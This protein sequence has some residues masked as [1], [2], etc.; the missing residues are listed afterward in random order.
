MCIYVCM[1][2]YIYTYMCTV[3]RY[4]YVTKHCWDLNQASA[5]CNTHSRS[6]IP[7]NNDALDPD[8]VCTISVCSLEEHY[9]RCGKSIGVRCRE[10]G[11][12]TCW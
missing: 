8:S 6:S 4:L 7:A 2:L 10:G 1:Y 9:T 5:I 11:I 3:Y 12:R